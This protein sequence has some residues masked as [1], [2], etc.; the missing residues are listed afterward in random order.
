MGQV[1]DEIAY[2][3][4]TQSEEEL[5]KKLCKVRLI[6]KIIQNAGYFFFFKESYLNRFLV[7]LFYLQGVIS[8]FRISKD[9]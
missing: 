4:L 7:N 8:N 3:P 6:R 9:K 5:R 1:E 2:V